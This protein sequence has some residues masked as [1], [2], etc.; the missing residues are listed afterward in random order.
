M[1]IISPT[2]TIS[3]VGQVVDMVQGS[4]PSQKGFGTTTVGGLAVALSS[5][6]SMTHAGDTFICT[7]I[8]LTNNY[9][10]RATAVCTSTGPIVSS[11]T[12]ERLT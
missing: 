9:F 12:I 5:V 1:Y 6:H 8:D 4:G 3:V 10:Y 7:A 11:V 2:S